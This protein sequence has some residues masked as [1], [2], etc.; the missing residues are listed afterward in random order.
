MAVF[1]GNVPSRYRRLAVYIV[2]GVSLLLM[3]F[4]REPVVLFVALLLGS[5][6]SVLLWLL[7]RNAIVR[8]LKRPSVRRVSWFTITALPCILVALLFVTGVM[9]LKDDVVWGAFLIGVGVGCYL[10]LF[11]DEQ[12]DDD[13]LT[14]PQ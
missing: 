3:T 6:G 7:L 12:N 14:S 4:V 11:S 9:G 5:V 13:K 10:S 2:T 8:R 1:F